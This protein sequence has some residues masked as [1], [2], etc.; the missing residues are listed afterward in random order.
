VIISRRR[1]LSSA[2]LAA[3]GIALGATSLRRNAATG[4]VTSLADRNPAAVANASGGLNVGVALGSGYQEYFTTLS[5]SGQQSEIGR[6]QAANIAWVRL[7]ADW[8]TSPA[9]RTTW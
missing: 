4:P 2:A 7:D 1:L 6:M 8:E 9:A 5:A 3:G